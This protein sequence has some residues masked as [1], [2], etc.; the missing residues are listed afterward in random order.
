LNFVKALQ[1]HITTHAD[2]F[3][4]KELYLIRNRSKKGIGFLM[5]QVFTQ[6]LLCG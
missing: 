6:T 1:K 5:M 2:H 3:M 4:D